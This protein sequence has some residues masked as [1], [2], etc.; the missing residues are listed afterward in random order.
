MN[1]IAKWIVGTVLVLCALFAGIVQIV[2]PG[3]MDKAI[4]YVEKT[5]AD[6]INGS[7]TV[8]SV[9]KSGLTEL[10]VKDI[11]VK[12]NRKRLVAVMPETR[13]SLNPLKAFSGVEK[14]VSSV[15]L[16]KPTLYIRQDKDEL[17]YVKGWYTKNYENLCAQFGID[18]TMGISNAISYR[19]E[20]GVIFERR[21]A[22]ES[23]YT[24]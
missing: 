9:S 7:V 23:S 24:V 2:L 19:I 22:L 11:T 3:L 1:R 15:E 8:G 4:P 10:L 13:I 18:N 16:V 5:A 14:A 12:D 20:S 21:T 17:E 6:Y